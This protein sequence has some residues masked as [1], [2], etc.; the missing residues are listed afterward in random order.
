MFSM[1]FN[2]IVADNPPSVAQATT[3]GIDRPTMTASLISSFRKKDIHAWRA[4]VAAAISERGTLRR[5]ARRQ[6]IF[7]Q[8]A[9]STAIYAVKTGVVETSGLNAGG[10]EVTLSIRGPGEAF[11]YSE[12]VLGTSRTRQ[13]SVVHEA[14]IWELPT[15]AF[16]DMLADRPN[17]TLAMLGS[18]LHRMTQS[19]EMRADLRGSSAHD[20]VGYVLS[21]LVRSTPEL[22]EAAHP[23]LRI[24]H[25]EISRLCDVSRQTVTTTLGELRDRGV[26]DLGLRSIT[27]LDRARLAH[28]GEARAGD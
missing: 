13:A 7:V 15:D 24:T 9:L 21:Q 4:E 10:R 22:A 1:R 17:L 3:R 19:S 6:V 16:M 25:E 26:V 23:T 20:R 28:D 5:F 18:A 8:G 12:A 11:G 27:V 2:D 14:E